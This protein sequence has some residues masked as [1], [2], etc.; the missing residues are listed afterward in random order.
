MS[1][2]LV[3]LLS[4]AAAIPSYDL[5]IDSL[6]L[7]FQTSVRLSCSMHGSRPF[8]LAESDASR[9]QMPR[10]SRNGTRR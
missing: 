6:V 8:L 7:E 5:D 3:E 2:R 4:E 10:G 9:C 1:K